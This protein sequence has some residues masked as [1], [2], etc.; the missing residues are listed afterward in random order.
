MSLTTSIAANPVNVNLTL[1]NSI[2]NIVG[3]GGFDPT[4][5][6]GGG[7]AFLHSFNNLGTVTL[8]ANIFDEAGYLSSFNFFN[9]T[10]NTI[11]NYI[12][13]SNTFTRSSN[14]TVVRRRGNR[15]TNVTAALT[16]NIFELGA[17]LDVFGDI[18]GIS[19]DGPINVFNTISGG[20]GI[21]GTN[22][23]I[24]G[25][26]TNS[27]AL[28]S[29][30]ELSFT[31]D[32][33]PLKYVSNTP[34]ALTLDSQGLG[35]TIVIGGLSYLKASA[36]GQAGDFLDA[37]T[38]GTA[39]TSYWAYGDSGNDTILGAAEQDY[40]DGGDGNDSIS[41]SS[42]DDTVLGG[43][44]D[45]T[46]SGDAGNDSI[47]GGDGNDLLDG[48]S[49]NDTILCGQ[50][51]DSCSGGQDNDS[52]VGELGNDTLSGDAGNDTIDGGDGTDSLS[53]GAGNDSIIGGDLADILLG[54][55]GSDTITGDAGIDTINGGTG[56]DLLTGGSDTSN[57]FIQLSTD[58]QAFTNRSSATA[59]AIGQTFTYGNRLDRITD[60]KPGIGG[61]LL[62]IQG[63]GILP[64][65]ALG[66]SQL[67]GAA[68]L[69]TGTNYFL[70]GIFNPI[71]NVFTVTANGAAG[72]S[73]IILQG[74]SLAFTS[75]TSAVLL[76]SVISSQLS[77]SNFI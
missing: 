11:G 45:D 15:L 8:E 25:P 17:F 12:I 73:T 42:G 50:G 48:S 46:I 22:D 67:T 55:A 75:N 6:N 69:V 26:L 44:G 33:L 66:R 60:F 58:S 24:L 72:S 68:G 20:F 19:F 56:A 36:G 16:N 34:G 47:D 40:L 59:F 28:T 51:D 10:D 18:G 57:N 37:A 62:D 38:T 65:S 76:N 3:Q 63:S 30:A 5:T 71:T 9:Q 49:G 23:P 1:S 74:N 21:R 7:S 35:G 54:D 52:I 2:V 32:G 53:G 70:S 41:S 27:I 39:T 13:S 14:T 77:A 29:T 4:V 61:D 43:L 31:G 64:T